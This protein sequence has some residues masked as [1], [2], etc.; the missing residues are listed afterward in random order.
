[1]AARPQSAP[2]LLALIDGGPAQPGTI[3]R[4]ALQRRDEHRVVV[5]AEF[6]VGVGR[7]D[8]VDGQLRIADGELELDKTIGTHLG[9][10]HVAL[11]RVEGRRAGRVVSSIQ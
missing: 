8:Q 9:Q 7:Q 4:R 10:A 3:D 6:A 2:V 5:A 1:M 11:C